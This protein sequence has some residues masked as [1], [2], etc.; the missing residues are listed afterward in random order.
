FFDA[1]DANADWLTTMPPSDWTVAHRPVGRV[2]LPTGSYA[3]MGEWALPADEGLAFG[4]ALRRARAEHLPEARWLRGAIWRNFQV[5]YREIN[6]IHKQMLATSDLVE[7]MTP[8]P[9]RATAL[10][11]L[12][13]GQSNDCYW[14]GLFGGI[15]L[16]DL[17]VAALSRL[18]AA[19]DLVIGADPPSGVRRDVDL[20]G[21]DE[22]VLTGPGQI[23]TVKLEEGGGIARW[24]LRAAAHP[25][26]AVMRRRP[27]AYH[28]TLRRHETGGGHPAEETEG[29]AP[30][31]IH[32]IVMVKQE[33][34]LEHLRYD[35]YE[36]RSG[37]I[38]V[39]PAGTTAEAAGQGTADELGDL[40]DGAWTLES[41]DP[42]RIVA[43]RSGRIQVATDSTVPVAATRTIAVLGGRLDP[44]IELTL[45]IV[46]R[47][48]PA[49][50]PI[51]AL[52]AVEWSTMLLGGGHNPSAWHDVAGERTAHDVTRAATAVS[53]LTA[54]NDFLGI[55]I[56]TTTDHPVDA[57]IGP[58]ETVSN[59]EA[60]FELV[61]QG[62][63]T[64]LVDPLRLA[65]GERWTIRITQQAA[66]AA[67]RF[68]GTGAG[69]GAGSEV[70]M[71]AARSD[72]TDAPDRAPGT[73]QPVAT[74]GST[75]AG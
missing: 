34:L 28:E 23:V 73:D 30:A 1:L 68:A 60:G 9:L 52:V 4:R 61:Y 5:R 10:D 71:G 64:L 14:H 6:D 21:R 11:H 72:D 18:I 2:Y 51:D 59:S 53:R 20:D 56:E 46:H 33:G 12:F 49:A 16:P 13:A 40:R 36:R 37:L 27:E 75:H 47:G 66:V 62:S 15:Y 43:R 50:P 7:A 25:L 38:R 74:G 24:D 41:L 69:P 29:G 57:W 67:E 8:G 19:E 54:G 32:D 58:I 39:L 22:V 63:A 44:R 42:R 55:S 70:G 31:S 35:A 3:E 65:P 48:E 45:E 26:A 17:R